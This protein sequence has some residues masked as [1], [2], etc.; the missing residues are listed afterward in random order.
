MPFLGV[1]ASVETQIKRSHTTSETP[2]KLKEK[3]SLIY[4]LNEI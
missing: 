3:N 2:K 1:E 4:N